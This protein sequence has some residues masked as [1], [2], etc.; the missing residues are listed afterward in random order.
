MTLRA[1]FEKGQTRD[2]ARIDTHGDDRE[3]VHT[4]NWL[5]KKILFWGS[6]LLSAQPKSLTNPYS[7][8]AETS[9]GR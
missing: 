3:E 4:L 7:F 9:G 2:K 6:N 1:E 5:I 8:F